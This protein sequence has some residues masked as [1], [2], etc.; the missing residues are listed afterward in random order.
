MANANSAKK[1][2]LSSDFL[3]KAQ[4]TL[5][6]EKLKLEK[7]LGKFAKRDPHAVEED[8]DATFPNYGDKEEDNAQEVAEY[9]ANLSIEHDLEKSLR[10]VNSALERVAGGTYGICRYCKK[11]IDKKRLSARPT[12]SACIDCK[13]TIRQEV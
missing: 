8:Y 12:S 1:V 6:D 4:Q 2:S 7:E 10:D 3:K 9:A 5:L 11:P 13:K